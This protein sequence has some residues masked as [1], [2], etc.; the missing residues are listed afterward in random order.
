MTFLRLNARINDMA[1]Q[2]DCW[3]WHRM[4]SITN[5]LSE[6]LRFSFPRS[7]GRRPEVPVN[8]ACERHVVSYRPFAAI[9]EAKSP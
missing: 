3:R 9:A 2:H 8:A 6:T 7:D 5:S 4:P 1:A